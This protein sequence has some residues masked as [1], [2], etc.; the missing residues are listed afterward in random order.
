MTISG[1]F[2]LLYLLSY[3]FPIRATVIAVS[4]PKGSYD[5]N[6]DLTTNTAIASPLLSRF[7][8]VLVLLDIPKKDHD[9]KISTFLL[10]RALK[11]PDSIRS[12]ANYNGVIKNTKIISDT[13]VFKWNLD[14]FRAYIIYCREVLNPVMS[15]SAQ[16]LLVI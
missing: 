10:Q 9:K 1:F 6:S 15:Q 2:L 8:L 3:L 11:V 14:S 13:D 16:L 7:D 12:S 4:N 5:V